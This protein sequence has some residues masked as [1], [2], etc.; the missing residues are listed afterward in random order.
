MGKR[1]RHME[2]FLDNSRTN[3]SKLPGVDE[4]FV[5]EGLHKE[6][7]M[8]QIRTCLHRTLWMWV[9]VTSF[10][11]IKTFVSTSSDYWKLKTLLILL[12]PGHYLWHESGNMVQNC[13]VK[14]N[15]WPWAWFLCTTYMW[16]TLWANW[17]KSGQNSQRGVSNRSTQN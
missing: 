12:Y 7:Q 14:C 16:G 10:N 1:W 8:L 3:C 15:L 13:N 17:S 9:P 2:N 4:V 5:Q 11:S 6:M